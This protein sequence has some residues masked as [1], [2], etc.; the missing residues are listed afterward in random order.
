MPQYPYFC[1]F[2]DD[3][4]GPIFGQW[5]EKTLSPEEPYWRDPTP[6]PAPDLESAGINSKHTERLDST[7]GPSL[8]P[9]R[10]DPDTVSLTDQKYFQYLD[11]CY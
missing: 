5:F 7:E 11:S 9:D 8:L 2:T 3:D 10:T 6:P 1:V 4:S